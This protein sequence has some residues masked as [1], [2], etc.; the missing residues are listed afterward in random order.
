MHVDQLRAPPGVVLGQQLLHG[1]LRERGV[2]VVARAVGERQLLRLHHHMPVVRRA[3]PHLRE[4]EVLEDVEHLE[5]REPLAIGR[6]L[7]HG[8]AMV[9]G[10]DRLVPG[11]VVLG[12][13]VLRE[14]SLVRH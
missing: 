10:G 8:V 11:R 13:I 3:P 14:E 2:G 4:V 6:Q 7:P 5:R 1:S 12:E 9:G